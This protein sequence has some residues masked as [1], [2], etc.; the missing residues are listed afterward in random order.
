MKSDLL[1]RIGIL[2]LR[3]GYIL[4][5]LRGSC[6]D[7]LARLGKNVLLIKVLEDANSISEE[8]SN[9][10]RLVASYIHGSPLI[11]SKKAGNEL[12]DNV[13]Y[14]RHGVY[15]LNYHTFRGCIENRF[16]FVVS[17]QAG[18]S[19]LVIGELLKKT[20]EVEGLSLASLA[21]KIGVSR[22][23]IQMYEKENSKITIKNAV[24][25]YDVLGDKVFQKIDIFSSVTEYSPHKQNEIT[26]KFEGLGFDA[27]KTSNV[28][29]DVLAKKENEVILTEV[30]DKINPHLRSMSNLLEVDNLTIYNKKKPKD[31]PALTKAEFLELEKAEELIKFLKEF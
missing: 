23:M 10:M 16:P 12:T 7:L 1:D 8:Y 28:P 31:I 17:D 3:K 20:R 4:K 11:I 25:L 9:E 2:L 5:N 27:T 18:I 21:Q 6:F 14:K 24:R 13:V 29:F 15:T 22:K 19:A 30:G 26:K